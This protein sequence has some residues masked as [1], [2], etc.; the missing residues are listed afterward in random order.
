MKK[1]ESQGLIARFIKRRLISGISIAYKILT[2][3]KFDSIDG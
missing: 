3:D 1:Y 2:E